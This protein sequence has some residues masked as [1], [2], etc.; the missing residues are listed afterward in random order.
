MVSGTG[1]DQGV[2]MNGP[3]RRPRA[4]VSSTYRDLVE[5][6]E[7]IRL[8]LQRL[9]LE[10]VAMETYT[11]GEERPLDRCLAD[12]R[13]TDLYIGVLAWRYGF[14]PA[15]Q[16][17]SIT[18]LEYL[19]AAAAG[20]PRLI[21]VL[22][23][24]A[25]WPHSAADR[26][27][28]PIEAF[29]E[30]VGT[31]L[32]CDTFT[33]AEHLRATVAEAVGRHLRSLGAPPVDRDA[34][35]DE[36]CRRLVQDY[37]RLDLDALTPPDRDE[38]LQ[39]ALRDVFVEP[40][41]RA[42][43]SQAE[44]PK[45]LLRRL[46][47]AGELSHADLPR[48][49][50]R[51]LFEQ[52][53]ESAGKRATRGAFEALTAP[54]STRSVL[55]GDPGAG[56]S[57]LARYVALALA[58][59]RTGT[60]FAAL[61]GWRP[62]LIEL[63]DYALRSDVYETFLAY[64]DYQKRTDQLGLDQEFL[65]QYLQD[66]GQVLVI[67][68]GLDEV[69][70]P[71][72]RQTVARRIAGFADHYPSARVVVTSRVVGYRPRI[73][74]DAG[75]VHY[76]MQDLNEDRID[77]FLLSWYELAL[78]DRPS[79]A[80]SRRRRL[81]RAI[82]DSAPIRELAGNP[83]LLTILAIIG[84]HQE[85]PRERWKVYEHAARVLVQHW[86]VNKHLDDERIAADVLREDD[87]IEI[88]RRLAIRMQEG[89]HGYAGNSLPEDSLLQDIESYLAGRFR[90]GP[91]QAAEIA[92]A[93]VSQLR[94]RNFI[95]ARYGSGIYGFVHRALLEFFAASEIVHQF[96]KT[97]LLS[98]EDLAAR[99]FI[100]KSEDPTW[101]EILRLIAGMVD[102]TVASRLVHRLLDSPGTH[103]SSALD[104]RPLAMVALAAQCI[105]EIR[106]TNAAAGAAE[107]TLDYLIELIAPPVR[108]F[109]N[110]NRAAHLR[111]TVL[112][113]FNAVSAW[114]GRARFREWFET[115]GQFSV[116]GPVSEM[117]AQFLAA[118]FPGDRTVR[119]TL[120]RL[121]RSAIP[122][123][124]EAALLA[125]A[126]VWKDDPDTVR[127]I[128]ERAIDSEGFVRRTA[129]DLLITH[130]P[131]DPRTLE[132]L[133]FA[134]TD[135]EADF[136][137]QAVEALARHAAHEPGTRDI[138]VRL[139]RT[140]S[141]AGVRSAAVRAVA[142]TWA[143]DPETV[144]LLLGACGDPAWDVRQLALKTM[145]AG[146]GG[147]P[148][149]FPALVAATH[150]GDEDVR[151]TAV[152]LL[153]SRWTDAPEAIGASLRAMADPHFKVRRTAV[154]VLAQRWP[155]DPAAAAALGRAKA[156]H[157][158]DVRVSALISRTDA[159]ASPEEYLEI[160][161]TVLAED[162][163]PDARRVALELIVAEAVELSGPAV[164]GALADPDAAVRGAAVRSL[165]GALPDL[166]EMRGAVLRLCED[167][168]DG[169]RLE[170]VQAA[171]TYWGHD[172]DVRA[173]LLRASRT[174]SWQ[175][176]RS[177]VESLVAL[178]PDDERTRQALLQCSHDRS[179][180][181]RYAAFRH[182]VA[183]APALTGEADY[184]AG[185]RLDP[186]GVIR[187][188]AAALRYE[189]GLS[190]PDEDSGAD[191]EAAL[192]FAAAQDPTTVPGFRAALNDPA[193]TV[194]L[195][196]YETAAIR[197]DVE[198]DAVDILVRASRDPDAD[199]RRMGLAALLAGW[200]D[201][202][203]T[204]AARLR[205]LNDTG[206]AVRR[207]ALESLILH[208]PVAA[209]TRP[210]VVAAL[211]D[212]DWGVRRLACDTLVGQDAGD[213]ETAEILR[214]RMRHP[215]STV[216][217]AVMFALRAGWAD[218]E[219]TFGAIAERL[220]DPDATVRLRALNMLATGWRD[221]PRTAPLVAAARR[222]VYGDLAWTAWAL[223]GA[224]P[225]ADRSADAPPYRSPDPVHRVQALD[226]LARGPGDDDDLVTACRVGLRDTNFSV[227]N[228]ALHALATSVDDDIADRLLDGADRHYIYV[229]R[230]FNLNLRRWRWPEAPATHRAIQMALH[231]PG[232]ELQ[233][234]AL[235]MLA[236]LTP[237]SSGLREVVAEHLDSTS[238]TMR[239]VAV[240]ALGRLGSDD[241]ETRSRLARACGDYS[242]EVRRA[243]LEHLVLRWPNAPE[244]RRAIDHAE[245]DINKARSEFATGIRLLLASPAGS[246]PPPRSPDI[247]TPAR[248]ELRRA[249]DETP[250]HPSS[251]AKVLDLARHPL[252]R[253]RLEAL[254][255]LARRWPERAATLDTLISA[256]GDEADSVRSAA[257]V[258]MAEIAPSS[259]SVFAILHAAAEDPADV[260]RDEA[261]HLSRVWPDTAARNAFIR[262]AR[263]DSADDRDIGTA[264]LVTAWPD[265]DEIRDVLAV[266]VCSPIESTRRV[267]HQWAA[268]RSARRGRAELV[269]A[270]NVADLRTAAL[271][272]GDHPE[273]VALLRSGM[274][275]HDD[276]F[277]AV[278]LD[279]LL[280]WT[281]REALVT[282]LAAAE[283]DEC[284]AVRAIAFD[285]R[286]EP[287]NAGADDRWAG[288]PDPGIRAE[289][290]LLGT[291]LA[292]SAR[293]AGELLEVLRE[294][295]DRA[296]YELPQR[297]TAWGGTGQLDPTWLLTSGA[298]ARLSSADRSWLEWLIWTAAPAQPSEQCPG[299]GGVTDSGVHPV[300]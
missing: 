57:T 26:D 81:G 87:K 257:I 119:G 69:F 136:R 37:R 154:N 80:E 41:V 195:A 228:L 183:L 254:R 101:S 135:H 250:D 263:A 201:H 163:I 159:V 215:K 7:E 157:D 260:V 268:M 164:A 92:Q 21:F 230:E 100:P 273:I 295:G 99:I 4:Y 208:R 279:G 132:R 244:T 11:A 140:D 93:M 108:S 296:P 64:L 261:L 248:E 274:S 204:A 214:A 65:D 292:G 173:A 114:P 170:A 2:R 118:L 189:L 168:D 283:S 152:E 29:R 277:R 17:K 106:N 290:W 70:E 134:A 222:S 131:S 33:S 122:D 76:T 232:D 177:A 9:G 166:A 282:E 82:K 217:E 219:H 125:L 185:V 13:S 182:R 184:L 160:L 49:L 275:V 62:V 210:A 61:E 213:P 192:Y 247:D 22:D 75:F 271:W 42:D 223:Q 19:E 229:I 269:A 285:A 102:A 255:A 107:R 95:F 59:G 276:V 72:L 180:S 161:G 58:E 200:P 233:S 221:D 143:D 27:L 241:R 39:I 165:S 181:V 150:D 142:S 84:K 121:T 137:R 272:W 91:A 153:A 281:A 242:Y 240:M 190:R 77:R 89:T 124:R 259:P 203:A 205:G 280:L 86:D 218:D 3:K 53:R 34:P 23:P 209:A 211:S 145:I 94:E 5:H 74:H 32:L 227:R 171:A 88:L 73:L 85:L 130:W 133:R 300:L 66:G 178:W 24:D 262:A 231:D 286:A 127:L 56:K 187:Y 97:R 8:A 199:N 54:L 156:D 113:A 151:E 43:L 288:D 174:E 239:L 266:A 252:W 115:T 129:L 28:G 98:E 15:G 270:D 12:V 155:E 278:S 172:A 109:G 14:V 206:V 60:S 1:E 294:L 48:G 128:V 90:Y 299:Q 212:S 111:K 193:P 179:S 10:D 245:S 234:A 216:R 194:R 162:P 45:A 38:H 224:E 291:V 169:V 105:A 67:F 6:R 220:G 253:I 284:P 225:P 78:H 126:A 79:A 298:T 123:Q 235:G 249:T 188:D 141:T 198:P 116:I 110:D 112:P 264:A 50:D 167:N 149:V 103:R 236:E 197:R 46:E 246:K 202:P 71:R 289:A 175:L 191:R 47:E 44:L 117:G 207:L 63:R 139:L 20:I 83:L 158:G 138:V 147:D 267:A 186:D 256:V 96:E 104:R 148:L 251:Y 237:E 52:A 35:W 238:W 146:F 265:D 18:E 196:G 55:L 36:Y 226:R 30:R 31:E 243:A 16:S 297:L 287:G 144:P 258:E 120:H 176:R 40:E 51:Q 68:D 293:Q 25:A